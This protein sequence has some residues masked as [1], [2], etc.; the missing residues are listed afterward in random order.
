MCSHI[1]RLLSNVVGGAWWAAS[2][3]GL[4]EGRIKKPSP[5]PYINII[6]V[7]VRV[8]KGEYSMSGMGNPLKKK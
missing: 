3:G 7:V 1:N 4:L 8:C 6:R 2:L 5:N